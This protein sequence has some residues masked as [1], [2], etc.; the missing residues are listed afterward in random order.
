MIEDDDLRETYRQSTGDVAMNANDY[1]PAYVRWLESQ[2]KS[3]TKPYYWDTSTGDVVVRDIREID[4]QIRGDI[5]HSSHFRKHALVYFNRTDVPP[6]LTNIA[7]Y[8]DGSIKSGY[9]EN[10]NWYLRIIDGVAQVCYGSKVMNSLK[11]ESVVEKE[12]EEYD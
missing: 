8:P 3:L 6:H 2:L 11:V 4:E 7:R 1:S 10:V 9:L 5:M 12:Y